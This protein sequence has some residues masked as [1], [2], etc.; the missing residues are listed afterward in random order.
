MC[1]YV[2]VM[3]VFTYYV[4]QFNGNQIKT[5]HNGIQA[6]NGKEHTPA[7]SVCGPL[8]FNNNADS[9]SIQSGPKRM[10]QL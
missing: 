6:V 5:N 10:Q 8:P 4:S 3:F 7:H 2:L 1:T 9:S